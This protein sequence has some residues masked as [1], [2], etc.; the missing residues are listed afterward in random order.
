M[1]RRGSDNPFMYERVR[2]L[3]NVYVKPKKVSVIQSAVKQFIMNIG[4]PGECRKRG[5]KCKISPEVRTILP[6]PAWNNRTSMSKVLPEH[7]TTSW[8]VFIIIFKCCKL[9]FIFAFH[10][11]DGFGTLV[12]TKTFAA[13]NNIPIHHPGRDTNFRLDGWNVR[14]IFV[15]CV[16]SLF[17]V[18]NHYRKSF[19]SATV[20]CNGGSVTKVRVTQVHIPLGCAMLV[21]TK[22]HKYDFY[23]CCSRN[24]PQMA[25]LGSFYLD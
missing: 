11:V 12:L 13:R 5:R 14:Y 4:E 18:S 10:F 20:R 7:H 17:C 23:M 8:H 2:Y 15:L 3:L 1:I 21:R 22:V 25:Q 16:H 19:L 9:V 6:D 24:F